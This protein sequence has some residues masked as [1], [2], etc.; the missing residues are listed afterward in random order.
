MGI[1]AQPLIPFVIQVHHCRITAA[2]QLRLGVAVMLHGLVEV[3]MILRQIG[4]GRHIKVNTTHPIQCDRM[5][6]N[7]HNCITAAGI[8]HLRKQALQL[9]AFGGRAIGGDHQISNAVFHGAD[10]ACLTAGD[11]FQH[12]LE[13]PGHRG[14]AVGT[15]DTD[16]GHSL[17][18]MMEEI[19]ADQRQRQPVIFNQDIR[20]LLFRLLCGD[21]HRCA[22]FHSHGNKAVAIGSK[23]GN[24][25][26]NATGRHL[27]GII[28]YLCDLQSRICIPL[29]NGHITQQ[30]F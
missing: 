20:N 18:G 23:T 27:A 6:G 13:Q 30:L 25:H 15:G 11:C 7:F 16:D 29:Q 9:E 28:N 19:A 2:E 4:E 3:Q 22:F 21:H 14:L 5:R 26:K 24:R 1:G 17:R 8:P 10:Q 12:L